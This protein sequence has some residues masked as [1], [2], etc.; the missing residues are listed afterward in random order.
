M[1]SIRDEHKGAI[2]GPA[3]VTPLGFFSSRPNLDPPYPLT[4]RRVC[5]LPL[6]FRGGGDTLACRRGEGETL[7][8]SG[9][10]CNL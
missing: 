5:P 7:W 9:F 6:W 10:I 2:K 4:R 8:F 1:T 3:R